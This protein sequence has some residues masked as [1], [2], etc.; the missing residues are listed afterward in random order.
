MLH[1]SMYMP[2]EWLYSNDLELN[3]EDELH[4]TTNYSKA[5]KRCIKY[6]PIAIK[7]KC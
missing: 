1:D 6:L 3:K 5:D 4:Q 2:Q 7:L